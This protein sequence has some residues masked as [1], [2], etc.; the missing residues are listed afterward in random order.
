MHTVSHTVDWYASERSYPGAPRFPQLTTIAMVE[1]RIERGDKIE[2][3]RRSY[4]S[5]RALS[6]TAFAEAVRGH[7]SIENGCHWVLDMTF[8]E[9]ESRTRERH[10]RENF[11][12]LNRFALSLLKQHPGRQSLVMK[13]R[14]CGWS[15]G[16]LM[17]VITG[18]TC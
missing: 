8:R 7:W 11:A 4:I 2:T 10:L 5:S 6:A 15:D 9:D 1:S 17:E 16:F 18:S 13:R 12:W 14:S 3:E